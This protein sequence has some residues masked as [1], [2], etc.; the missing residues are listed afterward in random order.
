MNIL[1]KTEQAALNEAKYIVDTQCT[2]R[3]AA[4][5]FGVGKSKIHRD[6]RK[7]LACLADNNP[8][9]NVLYTDVSKVLEFNFAE[10]HIRGGASTAKK[11]KSI[12]K[13]S[14]KKGKSG[15]KSKNKHKGNK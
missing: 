1:D 12:K 13:K 14:V 7:V 3:E 6:C 4:K 9:L 8:E 2:V 11:L 10:K 15:T 5:H